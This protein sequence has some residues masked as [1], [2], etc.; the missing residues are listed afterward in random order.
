MLMTKM[1]S[2][3]LA[4]YPVVLRNNLV[5]EIRSHAEDGADRV[6]PFHGVDS[7][8]FVTEIGTHEPGFTTVDRKRNSATPRVSDLEKPSRF[9]RN[10]R[11]QLRGA[12]V[13]GLRS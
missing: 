6:I 1:I 11:E 3:Q 7:G 12:N 10:E 2:H 8:F 4:S 9:S 13:S 5:A